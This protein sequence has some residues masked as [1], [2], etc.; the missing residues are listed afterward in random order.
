[1][2]RGY[3]EPID[4]YYHALLLE[5]TATRPGQKLPPILQQV[6]DRLVVQHDRGR[7]PWPSP[8]ISHITFKRAGRENGRPGLKNSSGDIDSILPG[9]SAK[10]HAAEK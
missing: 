5:G 4:Q 6:L 10:F 2:W 7:A 8:T 1:M 3:K 9:I